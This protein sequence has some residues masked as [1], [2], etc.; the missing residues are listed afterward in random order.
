MSHS[1]HSLLHARRNPHDMEAH[2][3]CTKLRTSNLCGRDGGMVVWMVDGK[4]VVAVCCGAVVV[5]GG[6]A[7]LGG[8]VILP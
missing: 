5:W 6:C 4:A 8:D 1:R 7:L 2:V 3:V